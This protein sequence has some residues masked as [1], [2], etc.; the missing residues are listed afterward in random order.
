MHTYNF[1][2]IVFAFISFY[3]IVVNGQNRID[4]N[5]FGNSEI[6]KGE[7]LLN[8]DGNGFFYNQEYFN[9]MVYSGTLGGYEFL[10]FA[11][12]RVSKNILLTTGGYIVRSLGRDEFAEAMPL[13]SVQFSPIKNFIFTFGSFQGGK[14]HRL[15]EQMYSVPQNLFYRHEEGVR[16]LYHSD[17]MFFDVWLDWRYLTYPNDVK[18]EQI[19]GGYSADYEIDMSLGFVLSPFTQMLAYHNGGQD[20]IV[21]HTVK[22][23]LNMS[24]GY[25]LN[26]SARRQTE[27]ELKQY[28]IQF[29][30]TIPRKDFP[31]KSGFGIATEF[32][33]KWKFICGTV[34]YWYGDRFYN[35]LG[36]FH[37]SSVSEKSNQICQRITKVPYMHLS[38]DTDLIPFV[39]FAFKGGFY[40][41][42]DYSD[43]D[44][45]VG[46]LLSYN[47]DFKLLKK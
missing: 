26:Y 29:F 10:T 34:G 6:K 28:Y 25:S 27:L 22:T 47:L 23:F 5:N 21:E 7:I 4:E 36:Q 33:G 39:N 2:Y 41:R 17:K 46:L 42:K 20:L 16:A 38:L 13:F 15:P 1:R 24:Y 8:V 40:A 30:N 11:N 19:F 31:Y 45:Y 35:P 32:T 9:P 43:V 18:T 44:F 3:S 12:Y 37:F 14:S